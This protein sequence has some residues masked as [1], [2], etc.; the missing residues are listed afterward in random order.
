MPDRCYELSL[1]NV[2]TE[3]IHP[4]DWPFH[5]AINKK[6]HRPLTHK[7]LW[8]AALPSEAKLLGLLTLVNER[9]IAHPFAAGVATGMPRESASGFVKF[10]ASIAHGH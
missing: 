8:S 4:D 10:A 7:V 6:R 3:A 9:C 2:A 5:R 1:S